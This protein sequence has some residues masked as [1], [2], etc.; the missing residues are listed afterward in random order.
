MKKKIQYRAESVERILP[1]RLVGAFEASTR[2][3][4]GVDVAKRNFVTALCNATGETVLRVRFEH[5]RQ[6]AQFVGLLA[7]LQAAERQVEVAMEPTGTYGDALRYRLGSSK[8]PVFRVSNKHVHDASE[9]FD[10][11]P[12]KHDGKDSSVIGWLHAQGRSKRWE[13][14]ELLAS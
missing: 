8:I 9:L 7:G 2:V 12:S 11:S 3:V 6:T 4:V 5:P 10:S 1:E 13:E 14:L